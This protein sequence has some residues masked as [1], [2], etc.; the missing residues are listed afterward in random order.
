MF[1]ALNRAGGFLQSTGRLTV[2]STIQFPGQSPLPPA[3]T[4]QGDPG[5]FNQWTEHCEYSTAIDSRPWRSASFKGDALG[6][7]VNAAQLARAYL[8][9]WQN[10]EN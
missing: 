1:V 10:I 4:S 7:A 6:H 2:A 9:P 5:S 8:Y 3:V